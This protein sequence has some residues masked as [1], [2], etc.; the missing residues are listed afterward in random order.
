MTSSWTTY[1]NTDTIWGPP[2]IFGQQRE[3][4]SFEK[5]ALKHRNTQSWKPP[6]NPKRKILLQGKNRMR[7]HLIRSK[8]VTTE[9]RTR[10]SIFAWYGFL[11]MWI[12]ELTLILMYVLKITAAILLKKYFCAIML[13]FYTCMLHII[14][15]IWRY[16]PSEVRSNG[17]KWVNFLQHANVCK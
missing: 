15:I 1:M 16:N 17:I 9:R 8:D 6:G 7:D 2:L 12:A 10:T 4:T 5:G 13:F 3:G 14:R 11:L